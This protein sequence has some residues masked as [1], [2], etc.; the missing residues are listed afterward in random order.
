MLE[1][2]HECPFSNF[3]RNHPQVEIQ[4]WCNHQHDILELKGEPTVLER[5]ITDLET[6]L[7]TVLRIFPEHNQ[8]Q[9]IMK[10]CK[11]IE[12]PLT[13]IIDRYDCLQLPPVRYVAGREIINL[14]VTPEDAGLILDNIRKEDPASK[15]KVLQLA[16]LKNSFN[17]YPLFLPLDGLKNSLTAKQLQVLTKAYNKGYYE[18]PRKVFL[19][20][21]A[22]DMNIHRRTY[23][24]HLRKA[25]KKIM[26]FLI[27][28]LIL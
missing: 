24:E 16:P 21:L 12:L 14:L 6:E 23:E 8:V 25:E 13:S 18:L 7:G 15:V 1:I 22:G 5:A 28:S 10:R 3:S 2:Q 11:C 27:P 19:E 26:S 4:Q 17:P 20:T 9:L